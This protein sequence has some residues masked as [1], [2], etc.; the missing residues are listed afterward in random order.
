MSVFLS[1]DVIWC[2]SMCF[3]VINMY[4]YTTAG[5]LF[6]ENLSTVLERHLATELLLVK[7]SRRLLLL[8]TDSVST[9][10]TAWAETHSLV[11]LT[12]L[13]KSRTAIGDASANAR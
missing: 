13:E 2:V 7:M 8:L 5:R 12:T 9:L 10:S 4:Q 11:V 6:V 1:V 3:D